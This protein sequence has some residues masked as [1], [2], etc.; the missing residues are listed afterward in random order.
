[1]KASM[2][3]NFFFL[4]SRT[5]RKVQKFVFFFAKLSIQKNSHNFYRFTSAHKSLSSESK[6]KQIVKNVQLQIGQRNTRTIKI[7]YG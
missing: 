3:V 5:S 4:S 6:P 7:F 2:I 1:M